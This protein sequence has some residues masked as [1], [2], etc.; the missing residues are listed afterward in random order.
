MRL[1]GSWRRSAAWT[2]PWLVSGDAGARRGAKFSAGS[3]S[4]RPGEGDVEGALRYCFHVCTVN[5]RGLLCVI[6]RAY[7]NLVGGDRGP[8]QPGEFVESRDRR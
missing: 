6:T 8:E 5:R 4:R 3:A 2:G 7:L 1:T